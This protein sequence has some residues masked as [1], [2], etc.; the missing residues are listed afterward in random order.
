M[1]KYIHTKGQFPFNSLFDFPYVFPGK[2]YQLFADAWSSVGKIGRPLSLSATP[3][4]LRLAEALDPGKYVLERKRCRQ[5]QGKRY[6]MS[7]GYP[8]GIMN[9]HGYRPDT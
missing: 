8:V 2:L 4:A 6:R 5:Y 3:C 9:V 7:L 1:C